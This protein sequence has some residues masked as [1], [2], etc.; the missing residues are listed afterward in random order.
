M[1]KLCRFRNM[2]SHRKLD[3][4]FDLYLDVYKNIFLKQQTV[5]RSATILWSFFWNINTFPQHFSFRS[6]FSIQP[7]PLSVSPPVG[8]S[9]YPNSGY[10]C[11]FS[12]AHF[13][14]HS[15]VR[16]SKRIFVCPS[17]SQLSP[18]SL[19][20]I[21]IS[22]HHYNVNYAATSIRRL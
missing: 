1:C 7:S 21:L 5:F 12:L 15:A 9:A 17:V 20:S 13:I 22:S 8:F 19:W 10:R 6:G 4:S 3:V 16:G 2:L 11:I 14:Y 18:Q